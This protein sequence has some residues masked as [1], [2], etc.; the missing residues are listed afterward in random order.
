MTAT[1]SSS[2]NKREMRARTA[3][4][5]HELYRPILRGYFAIFAI[6]YLAMTPLNYLD[7]AGMELVSLVGVSSAAAA[8]G[9]FGAWYMRKPAKAERV[10]WLL[11]VMN[12]LVVANVAIALTIDFRPEK[13]TYFIIM[14]M[15]FALAS[16]SFRQAAVSILICG[17]VLA[18]F[19][20]GLKPGAVASYGYLTDRK[21]VV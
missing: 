1:G 21:S 9:L 4:V 20:P 16:L 11:L 12:C 7:T 13:V 3:S 14:A 10:E 6:Y 18:G 8:L 5:V 15:L 19:F 2:E 17:I